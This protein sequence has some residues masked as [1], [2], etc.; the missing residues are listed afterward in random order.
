M[1]HKS[2]TD[3]SYSAFAIDIGAYAFMRK[4]QDRFKEIDVSLKDAKDRM[5]SMPILNPDSFGEL[6]QTIPDNIELAILE[7][8]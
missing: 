2:T 5:R 6:V 8:S 4:H 3:G 7:E 1:T